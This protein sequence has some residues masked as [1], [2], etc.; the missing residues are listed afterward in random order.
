[1]KQKFAALVLISFVAAL[2]VCGGALYINEI[3]FNPPGSPDDPNEYIEF[4][5]SPNDTID[6]TTYFLVVDGSLGDVGKVRDVFPLGGL[7]LGNNGFLALLQKGHSYTTSANGIVITNSGSEW[8]WGDNNGSSI[9]HDGNNGATN[10][11]NPSITF[12]LVQA[13][14]APTPSVNIDANNDGTLDGV[15]AG[16]TILDAVGVLDNTG[17]GERAFGKINFRRNSAASAP[18]TIVATTFTPSYV[19]RTTNSTGWAASDWVASD[20]TGSTP[21]WTLDSVKTLPASFASKILDHIGRANFGATDLPGVKLVQSG[22]TTALSENG[23]TDSYTLELNSTPAGSVTIQVS[24]DSQVQISSD[25]GAN[26][27]ST[28]TLTFSA[29]NA[30]QTITVRAVNDTA[31]ET[32]VHPGLITHAITATGDATKY[33]TTS[34]IPTVSTQVSDND[35]LL[36]NEV[37]VNP[38]G[39]P[40]APNEFVEIRGTASS[41]IANVYLVSVDGSG[42]NKGKVET[43]VNLSGS[44]LGTSGQLIVLGSGHPY[45]IPGT[46][47]TLI[48]SQF[49]NTANTEGALRNDTISILLIASP[50]ALVSGQDLDPGDTGTLSLPSG[51]TILDSVAWTDGTA[52][53][54]AYGGA[55]ITQS[56]FTPDAATRFG[57]NNNP[58]SAA[59]WFCGELLDETGSALGYDLSKMS[60]NAPV[61]AFLTPGAVNNMPPIAAVPSG[62]SGVL[63]DPTNPSLTF[64]V[65]D[66]ETSAGSLSVTVASGDTV[67][68]PNARITL[69]NLGGGNWNLAIAPTNLCYD[70]PINLT[71]G[72]GASQRVQTIRYAASLGWRPNATFH[73]GFANASSAV[74]IDANYMLVA[75]DE[76]HALKIVSRTSSGPALAE[77]DFS[78]QLGL[79]NRDET[80]ALVESDFEASTRVNDLIYWL[81]SQSN[82]ADGQ[83]RPNRSPL[84]ATRISGTGASSTLTFVGTY[85]YLRED[86]I[87]WDQLG[88]HG[89]G[90]AYYGLAASGA[91]FHVPKQDNGFN[92]EGLTISLNNTNV[93]LV[94]FRAP[95]VP[96]SRRAKALIV[97][98]TNIFSLVSGNLPAGS[99]RFGEPFELDLNGRGIRSIERYS[100]GYL[101]VAGPSGAT[102]EDAYEFRLFSWS[103]D[104]NQ[105]PQ[106][107]SADLSGMVP[108]GIVEIPTGSLT[109]STQIQLVSDN[110]ASQW[111]LPLSDKTSKKLPV[112]NFQKFRVDWIVLGSPVSQPGPWTEN[113]L[114]SRG[115]FVRGTGLNDDWQSF[116]ANLDGVEGVAFESQGGIATQFYPG[117]D[118]T[119]TFYHFNATNP[120]TPIAF[121]NPIA[122]FGSE[123]GGTPLMVDRTYT[124]KVGFG[125]RPRSAPEANGYAG[126]NLTVYNRHTLQRLTNVVVPFGLDP[127]TQ[128]RDFSR[129]GI[130]AD[131]PQFGITT[132]VRPALTATLDSDGF[133]ISHQAT[134]TDYL[135]VVGGFGYLMTNGSPRPT[136]VTNAASAAVSS[137]IYTVSFD[138]PP[139]WRSD[140]ILQPHFEGDPLPPAYAGKTLDELLYYS[141]QITNQ[142]SGGLPAGTYTNIDLSP[143]LRRHPILDQFVS[144]MGKDPVALANYVQ[145][146]IKLT[147]AFTYTDE[148]NGEPSVNHGGMNRGA[149]ATFIEGQG[150]PLEQSAL[151][152]YLLRQAGTPAVYVF[153]A[154][155]SLKMIDTRLSRLLRFQLKSP[156]STGPR[157]IP[158]N[159][160]WVA[161]YTGTNWIHLF[162]WLKDT[163]INEGFD[164]YDFLPRDFN[165]GYKWA[166]EYLRLNSKIFDFGLAKDTPA[167]LFPRF[168]QNSLANN[169]PGLSL[170]D[171]GAR[172]IDRKHHYPRWSDFPAPTL[173]SNQVMTAVESMGAVTNIY[174][175][176]T[177]V[178]NT[179]SVE[180][181]SV[182]NPAKKVA[183]G[184]IRVLDLHN[185]RLALWYQPTGSDHR[186]ILTLESF[187]P[188]STNRF[189][190]SAVQT[191]H[192]TNAQIAHILSSTNVLTSADD[193]LQMNL[194]VK[195]YLGLTYVGSGPALSNGIPNPASIQIAPPVSQTT[196]QR[197]LRKGDLVAL[198]VNPGVVSPKMFQLLQERYD[199]LYEKATN[200]ATFRASL[201][202]DEFEGQRT[203]LLAAYYFASVNR[204]ARVCQQLHKTQINSWFSMGLAKFGADRNAS[205]LLPAG[206]ITY[207]KAILDIFL[208]EMTFAGN[209]TVHPE[210]D[211]DATAANDSFYTILMLNSAAQEHAALDRF[212]GRTNA[213]STVTLLQKAMQK[214]SVGLNF[215][216][217][218][219]TKTNYMAE[220]NKLYGP[221]GNQMQLK[222]FDP[223]IWKSVTNAF[224]INGISN[225]VRVLITKGFVT[226]AVGAHFGAMI[227]GGKYFAALLSPTAINGS[228]QPFNLVRKSCSSG[229]VTLYFGNDGNYHL[230]EWFHDLLNAGDKYEDGAAAL[231]AG[232]PAE[233]SV[234]RD[235]LPAGL[236]PES[237]SISPSAPELQPYIQEY[238]LALNSVLESLTITM[239]DSYSDYSYDYYIDD[240]ETYGVAWNDN[241]GFRFDWWNNAEP[242]F[243]LF[244]DYFGISYGNQNDFLLRI[245]DSG[246]TS[247][248]RFVDNF[249]F[250]YSLISDPVNTV[251]GEFYVNEED[252]TLPGP[253]PLTLRRTYSS[254]NL[255]DNE[256]GYGWNINMFSYLVLTENAAKIYSVEP[257][258]SVVS[259]KKQSATLWTPDL[260]DNKR[261][262]NQNQPGQ[263]NSANMLNSKITY[264]QVGTTN[265]YKI[266]LPDGSVRSYQVR[267]FPK[268]GVNRNRPYLSDWVDHRGNGITFF[269]GE[270]PA[271]NDY[272]KIRRI[273]NSSGSALTLSYNR[274]E[275]ID[276]IYSNDGRRLRYWYDASGDD[277][278][279]VTLPSGSEVSYGYD[280][281]PMTNSLS[282]NFVYGWVE[283]N[284]NGTTDY[285]KGIVGTS[286][287]TNYNSNHRIIGEIK[288]EGR[289][290][291]NIYDASGRVLQQWSSSGLDLRPVRSATFV[292][293][294]NFAFAAGSNAPSGFT[295]IIDAL[296]NTN[297]YEYTNGFVT[298]ITDPLNQ[299]V[300]QDWY[301]QTASDGSYVRSLKSRTDQRGMMQRFYYDGQGNITTNVISG[302]DLT[303]DG[304]TAATFTYLYNTNN[305]TNLL[306]RA[307]DPS[308]KFSETAYDAVYQRLPKFMVK[309]AT[310]GI[311]ITTNAFFYTNAS[312]ALTYTTNKSFGVLYRTVRAYG[313]SDAATNDF[314]MDGRGLVSKTV[315][316]TSTIDSNII[317]QFFYN[318]RGELVESTNAAGT[319]TRNTYDDDGRPTAR[320]VFGAGKQSPS[321]WDLTYYNG[322]GEIVWKDGSRFDP[323]DYMWFDYDGSG[324]VTEVVAWRSRA[325]SDG[326]GVEAETGDNLY[327]TQF[328]EYD[329]YGNLVK[330]VDARGN[331]ARMYYDARGQLVRTVN[332]DSA[333][334]ALAT[335]SIAYDAAGSPV[336]LTNAI[337][338]VTEMQYTGTG[339]LKFRKNPDGSTN[340]WSY[341]VDGTPRREYLANGQYW[342]TTYDDAKRFIKRS[343]SG[344]ASASE[345]KLFDRRGNLLFY[346]NL[347]GAVF[348]NSYDGLDRPKVSA[349]P[350]A[351]GT[352]E[353]QIT[354]YKYDAT[355]R[356][357]VTSNILGDYTIASY[358]ILGRPVTNATYNA[359]GT[360][361]S[362]STIAYS[363]NRNSVTTTAGSGAGAIK[364][365]AFTD[366]FGRAVLTQ[367]FPSASVTNYTVNVYDLGG[368][369]L[370]TQDELGR[371]T[372]FTYDGLNRLFT[373]VYPDGAV[374]TLGYNPVGALTNRTMPGGLTWSASYDGANR[375]VSEQLLGGA[376]VNRRFSYQ[377]FGNGP[378]AG[379]LQGVI[380]LGR[381]VTNSLVYD[382]YMRVATNQ[383]VGLIAEQ[384]MTLISQYDVRG[385]A[386]NSQQIL[387]GTTTTVQKTFDGYGQLTR[388][389]I[390]VNGVTQSEFSQ[391]WNG[392]G[393]RVQLAQIGGGTGGTIYYAYRA[394]GLLS[395]VVQAEQSAYFNYGDHGLLTSRINPW[396]TMTVSQ[397]DGIG[398]LLQENTVVNGVNVLA[399]TLTWRADSTLNSYAANR[400]G[401][402]AWNESRSFQYNNRGQLTNEPVGLVTGLSATNK[403]SFDANKLGVL[404]DAQWSGGLSNRWQA[405]ALNT[406]G[407]I[408]QE[409]LTVYGLTLRAAGLASNATAIATSLD[410]APVTANFRDGRWSTDI[411]MGVGSHALAASASY[412]VGTITNSTTNNFTVLGANGVTELFDGAGNITNRVFNSG[413]SQALYWDGLGRLAKVIQ[414]ESAG[415]G[416]NWAAIY[417]GFGR[418]IRTTETPVV[419]NVTNTAA[420]VTVDSFYDPLVEFQEIG[421]SLNGL[422]TWKMMGVD[423]DARYGG[424]QGA[425]GTEATIREIDGLVT[426]VLNDFFGNSLATVLLPQQTVSWNPARVNSYGPVIGY[427]TSP[428]SAAM[429]LGEALV[430][431]GKR[432]D[433]TGF[434]YFGARYYD[435]DS[436]RFLSPDPL[437]HSASMS[438][439]DFCSGDPLNHF[440]PDG[441]APQLWGVTYDPRTGTSIGNYSPDLP[442]ILFPTPSSSGS[443]QLP[444]RVQGA[445]MMV[446]GAG[447]MTVGVSFGTVT[448]PTVGGA[449]LG[450][451]ITA[452][453]GLTFGAGFH[454]MITGEHTRTVTSQGLDYVTGNP[455]ASDLL[456][457]G[458][459]IALSFGGTSY[460]RATTLP[461]F[462]GTEITAELNAYEETGH[463]L[464]DSART[465]YYEGG[466]SLT[467]AYENAAGA[468]QQWLQIW[469]DENTFAQAHSAFGLE[470]PQAFGVQ[471]SLVSV[472]TDSAQAAYFAGENGTVFSGLAT[473]SSLIEQTLAGAGESEFLL[474]YG[475]AGF[476]RASNPMSLF[477]WGTGAGAFG[478]F[479]EASLT[480]SLSDPGGSGS[481]SGNAGLSLSIGKKP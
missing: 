276:E 114:S 330:S 96:L 410:G 444:P 51:A 50:T 468:H 335:N 369:L 319:R 174:P 215:G 157:L 93:A 147:D 290:V 113:T 395:Q 17:T 471:R 439:Y 288:P 38:A 261:L 399:E 196:E 29:A 185:R 237:F 148:Q 383:T 375:V 60:A 55:V 9:G 155:N 322:N 206:T 85:N 477:N 345:S 275:H 480:P 59:A 329:I 127:W 274:R 224:A 332:F 475:A 34:L 272:G 112:A 62:W 163:E 334:N 97:P 348:T 358:D 265:Y 295:L 452:H 64:S 57:S 377:Y 430:W 44:S 132:Y 189:A 462:R 349:G 33:P 19:G 382:P 128:A 327:A 25:G 347:V 351:T 299:S 331:F 203:H 228:E 448:S 145:N 227:L 466:S 402:G 408:T 284:N 81:A 420:M 472:T 406:L 3:L 361:V 6:S 10:M 200:N 76:L 75:D 35:V 464:S 476:T 302:A 89:K 248:E 115:K 435:S 233:I 390:L 222:Q 197:L 141:T 209:G 166:S 106:E 376:A 359:S 326:T 52:G 320:E 105:Q 344:D 45:S 447:E 422:R 49:A 310:G 397:R 407:Q 70:V 252:I 431:R 32:A 413:K 220:G 213:I 219:L 205:D 423:M 286:V 221:P 37:K 296:G 78:D 280:R 246:N 247:W 342:E 391:N 307:T 56:T 258:G 21:A 68:L 193:N 336:F 142:I 116:V 190:F 424:M 135:L 159:Y 149:L 386:T 250:N 445:L 239:D 125:D 134:K 254:Q 379:L 144:D 292:Y 417:D 304:V 333:G 8:G 287:V 65:A 441:R 400:N 243:G 470:M 371:V 126:V 354:V 138:R 139:A 169:Y 143:E 31:V 282:T 66:A 363:T 131:L 255:A 388:E 356:Q 216:V 109:S 479:G 412:A 87:K 104:P 264:E 241:N 341:Y 429:P 140:F 451:A 312:T 188:E 403:Y 366:T 18:N 352:S 53:E 183:S 42:G 202:A 111:Y 124:F 77:F 229:T 260:Q 118:W 392:T 404:V 11:E 61:G 454:Q 7:S 257:N 90:T 256:F 22:G 455:T 442:Y 84:F 153:P 122:A 48:N 2:R 186:M 461:V 281:V 291:G 194:A 273:L 270:D 294:N 43:V 123:A 161:A 289:F 73:L 309:Y 385:L 12:M 235:D 372:T 198:C 218:E 110:G 414:R 298:K 210:R 24:A 170:D 238:F 74:A 321:D 16:W 271:A 230:R 433:P 79:T 240:P 178:F 297:R 323:E 212:F 317:T 69:S 324:R 285:V 305:G 133:Y 83:L 181:V 1:M 201:T 393:R 27:F 184:D 339:K 117:N 249:S 253:F 343:F 266:R 387:G 325:K 26:W 160:P 207:Q 401:G 449:V 152:V 5:G 409:A 101:I 23:G 214:S 154:H 251:T 39:S 146:E 91:D 82:G 217:M 41:G 425:G 434:Y 318:N 367:R 453:G 360:R 223:L 259:Y 171:L 426:P 283:V 381:N 80:G 416:F 107:L 67:A 463:I 192:P 465:G 418:R 168:V 436:G 58:Q 130:V 269:F 46:T 262:S 244:G 99:A 450:V 278:I 15:A 277:L 119:T 36:L 457:G 308:G 182:A 165:S 88:L 20:L 338:G 175:T 54:L 72:D 443:I 95:L 380:D 245:E 346:T 94:A 293:S 328:R 86:I 102:T 364:T 263:P 411:S 47:T 231:L 384:N 279:R 156:T 481:F 100:S 30:P 176:F 428:I 370:S 355:G 357:L 167:E 306:I 177:N 173:L 129:E 340:R 469:G 121:Q 474:R 394:D 242:T 314:E 108:E 28:R 389:K 162:P 4:R 303:G 268:N 208:Q 136:L 120:L 337:G 301:W 467:S 211:L 419:S 458:L 137:P 398:R 14:S 158:V 191:L 405:A 225:S 40:D 415:N 446:G 267:Q 195:R 378:N 432:I 187:R 313:S 172:I 438:L 71:I 421:V 199:A 300:V 13:A 315:Q 234:C 179:V 150:S 456:D 103:G 226:N 353:Q 373:Q 236:S 365:T 459:G 316:Y 98:V 151:L 473:R 368:N 311:A 164:V 427:E 396:R 92:I 460:I 232:L 63:N 437:G 204:F 350:G 440:D 180:V 362:F 478:Y 374:V